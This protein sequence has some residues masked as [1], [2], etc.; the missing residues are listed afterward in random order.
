[1]LLPFEKVEARHIKACAYEDDFDI[2]IGHILG[3]LDPVDAF[4]LK[5]AAIIVF[6]RNSPLFNNSDGMLVE[7]SVIETWPQLSADERI[8]FVRKWLVTIEDKL[9][10]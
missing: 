3:V 2:A 9:S 7:G 10:K 4:R 8:N 1:M 6:G 5:S